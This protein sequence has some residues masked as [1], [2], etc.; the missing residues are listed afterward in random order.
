MIRLLTLS[1]LMPTRLIL[2]HNLRQERT[3]MRRLT[4]N[5]INTLIINTD[6]NLSITTLPR[7]RNSNRHVTMHRTN[8][9]RHEHMI[10]MYIRHRMILHVK[11]VNTIMNY[12]NLH[13]QTSSNT[14]RLKIMTV[15][16][17]FVNIRSKRARR[18]PRY[19][20]SNSRRN[21]RHTPFTTSCK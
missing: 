18:Y 20:S 12:L 2:V 14:S 11:E 8:N 16:N 7:Q 9:L 4:T 21:R 6:S 5:L 10:I 17:Q 13:V 3:T 15:N 1:S 19:S